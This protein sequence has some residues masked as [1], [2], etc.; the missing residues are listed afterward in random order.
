VPLQAG[1]LFSTTTVLSRFKVTPSRNEKAAGIIEPAGRWVSFVFAGGP[2]FFCT[3]AGPR[4]INLIT[5]QASKTGFP[6]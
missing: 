2:S 3:K 5:V 6:L 4:R 1:Q